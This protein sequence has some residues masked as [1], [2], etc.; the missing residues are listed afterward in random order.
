VKAITAFLLILL[1]PIASFLFA[2]DMD[3]R[4]VSR[5]DP[6]FNFAI[7]QSAR[8]IVTTDGE[9]FIYWY[10]KSNTVLKIDD[11]GYSLEW[12]LLSRDEEYRAMPDPAAYLLLNR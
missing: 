10:P 11:Y 4:S 8:L 1:L 12:D 7:K 5:I 9:W 2:E 3:G 6:G